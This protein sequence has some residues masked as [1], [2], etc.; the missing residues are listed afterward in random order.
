MFI[1]FQFFEDFLSVLL[2]LV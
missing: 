2:L 1:F